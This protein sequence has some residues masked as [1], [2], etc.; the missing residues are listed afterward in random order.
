MAFL[1]KK[2]GEDF[3]TA[4]SNH[5]HRNLF[6]QSNLLL[7]LLFFFCFCL[8]VFDLYSI[9]NNFGSVNFHSLL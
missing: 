4:L 5:Y 6:M 7:M 9:D 8:C 2:T 1:E 3:I